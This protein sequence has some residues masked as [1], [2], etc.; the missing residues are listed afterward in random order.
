MCY[1]RSEK[2][3]DIHFAIDGELFDGSEALGSHRQNLHMIHFSQDQVKVI[4][5]REIA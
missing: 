5:T 2:L 1:R 4:W 3:E